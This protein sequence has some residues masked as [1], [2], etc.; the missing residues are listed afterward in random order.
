MPSCAGLVFNELAQIEALRNLLYTL[1]L[2]LPKILFRLVCPKLAV[3]L[4]VC[5]SAAGEEG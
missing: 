4:Q 2:Q 1:F 5:L 3:P